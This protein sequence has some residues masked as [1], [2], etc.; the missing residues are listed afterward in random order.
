M[1]YIKELLKKSGWTSIVESL[2]FG[3]LGLILILRPDD[4]MAIIAYVIGAIFIAAGVIK[5]INY[6][7]NKGQSDLYNYELIYGIMAAVLG[8]IVIIHKESISRIFGIIMGMWIIYSSVVRFSSAIKLRVL[9]NN[10]W[11][12]SVVIAIIM[13]I[14]GLY[15]ALN[16]ISVVITVIG[17]IMIVYAVLDIIEDIIFIK[18]VNKI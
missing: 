4:I 10:I 1:E 6:M 2:V 12:Y 18:N 17:A 13:F 14:C 8:L 7:Q 5:I 9:N 16:S 3:I 15:I 11:I